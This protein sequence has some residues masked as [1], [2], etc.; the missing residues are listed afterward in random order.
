MLWGAGYGNGII[1][2]IS[3]IHILVNS[4]ENELIFWKLAYIAAVVLRC[5]GN[6]SETNAAFMAWTSQKFV[7]HT[8]TNTQRFLSE[9]KQSDAFGGILR[10][11][12]RRL[13]YYWMMGGIP[14][15]NRL[16]H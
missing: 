1:I 8:T 6:I 14:T 3:T 11:K 5:G 13:I 2:S 10:Q 15:T 9:T 7:R 4:W 16:S 12:Y